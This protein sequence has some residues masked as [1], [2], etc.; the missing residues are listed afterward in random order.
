MAASSEGIEAP[1]PRNW[2]LRETATVATLWAD[3]ERAA[4]L[5]RIG[6]TLVE[7]A[8]SILEQER[9][10]GA[11]GEAADSD[12]DIDPEMAKFMV[13][14]SCLD[15]DRF[16]FKETP[17]GLAVQPT[18]PQEAVQKMQEGKLEFERSS[19]EIRL[20]VRYLVKKTE[21][22][23]GSSEAGPGADELMADVASARELLENPA[24]LGV[25][26]PWDVPASVAAAVLEA[27]LLHGVYLPDGALMFAAET[28]LKISEG[29]ASPRLY[30]VEESYFEQGADRSAARALPLL[31]LPV[32]V[33]LRAAID[34][35][36]GSSTFDRVSAAGL[37]LAQAMVNEVRLHLALGLDHLWATPCVREGTCHHEVGWRLATATMRD[38]VLGGWDRDAGMRSVIL[39]DEPLATSLA[40]TP[41][42]SIQPFRLDA[43][44]R[45]LASVAV[46][47]ICVSTDARELLTVLLDAQRRALIRH[48]R[49]N[50]DHRGT[51]ALV[52]AR[53]LLTLAQN[54][55]DIVVYE[56]I[57]DYADSSSHLGNL[58]RGL[59]AAAEETPDRAATERGIWPSVIRH[60]LDL[61]SAGHTP[62]E[63]E[64]YGDM[65]LAALLPNRTSK[66]LSTISG[67][68]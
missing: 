32:A 51:Y 67:I 64:F 39:L 54:G 59:S 61:D 4:E 33:H 31:L 57:D 25:H 17:E 47:N 8:R 66:N 24:L 5:R 68:G 2:S 58:L 10:M 7:K 60:V 49:N 13:W 65:A 26:H 44:I 28:V 16:Q 63:G 52:T 30:D 46:A 37:N 43:S 6:E 23:T 20:T 45:A 55:D 19:E 38:C 21:M 9:A 41:D 12:G 1:D 36:D 18:P 14:A 11:P 34:G 50:L 62:F 42:D 56:Q 27:N 29:A 22:S 35:T 15:R 48:K 3:D 40:S 53:A